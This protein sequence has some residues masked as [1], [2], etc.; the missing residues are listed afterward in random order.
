MKDVLIS[1]GAEVLSTTPEMVT[2]EKRQFIF[3]AGFL[4][5]CVLSCVVLHVCKRVSSDLDMRLLVLFVLVGLLIVQIEGV[6]FAP[7]QKSSGKTI[8]EILI[9]DQTNMQG[10]FEQFEVVDTSNYPILTVKSK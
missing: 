10:I 4:F 5:L 3:F 7:P 1:L 9:N 6:V 8:F 2:D